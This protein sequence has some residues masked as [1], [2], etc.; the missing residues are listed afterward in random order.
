MLSLYLIGY[1]A[2]RF[3]IEFFREPDAH[4]GLIWFSLSMGQI[5]C[6]LMVLAGGLLLAGLGR[7]DRVRNKD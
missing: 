4:L 5:L 3:V 6:L 2:V 7:L 1:G